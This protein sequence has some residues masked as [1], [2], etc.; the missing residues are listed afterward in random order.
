VAT[1]PDS[2]PARAFR[3]TAQAVMA[4]LKD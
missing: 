4:Q 3:A 2:A 1:A